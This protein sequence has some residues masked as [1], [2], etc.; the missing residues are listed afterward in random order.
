MMK[1]R[2]RYYSKNRKLLFR[3]TCILSSSLLVILFS[4]FMQNH[5]FETKRI[6]NENLYGSWHGAVYYG[7]ESKIL[8]LL[9]NKMVSQTG[10]IYVLGDVQFNNVYQ[11]SIG[12]VD[13]SFLELSNIDLMKGSMPSKNNE[14]AIEKMKLDQMGLDYTLNQTISIQLIHD[15]EIIT[16][17]YQLS[18]IVENYSATWL[19]RGR[20][21]SF[22][23]VDDQ[24]IEP[25]EKSVFFKVKD[26]YL[27]S[28][29]DLGQKM[30]NGLVVNT[31]VE[32]TYNP[33]SSQNLPYTL[34]FGFEII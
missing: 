11:G 17:E 23:I 19:S 9:D 12:Y 22:F 25:V 33:L 21:L 4:L 1:H 15:D 14:I 8:D 13:D 5:L 28:V 30:I 29:Y 32:F 10:S 24:S 34:L 2:F 20:L 26:G 16:R 7:T 6:Q 31:N 27:E 3:F 18:G